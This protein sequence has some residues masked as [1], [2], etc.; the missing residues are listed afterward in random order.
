MSGYNKIGKQ[1]ILESLF[2]T[3]MAM[4]AATIKQADDIPH[5]NIKLQET[6]DQVEGKAVSA[7][8]VVAMAFFIGQKHSRNTSEKVKE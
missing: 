3:Y 1:K 8:H 6:F 4:K 5:L 7:G 2:E